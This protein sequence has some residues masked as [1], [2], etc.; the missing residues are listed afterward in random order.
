MLGLVVWGPKEEDKVRSARCRLVGFD[1]HISRHGDADKW[2]RS[3]LAS[4]VMLST[5]CAPP[6]EVVEPIERGYQHMIVSKPS[7]PDV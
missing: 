2:S 7:R 6:K 5:A 3:L 1:A 4:S